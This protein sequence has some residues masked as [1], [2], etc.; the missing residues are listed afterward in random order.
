VTFFASLTSR[1]PL[2]TVGALALLAMRST[3]S[4]NDEMESDHEIGI[5]GGLLF[6]LVRPQVVLQG[7]IPMGPAQL[8]LRVGFSYLSLRDSFTQA[9]E[10][11]VYSDRLVT[12]SASLSEISLAIPEATVWL[13]Q[14]VFLTAGATIRN[15]LV[16]AAYT[17][18]TDE[19][20]TFRSLGIAVGATGSAGFR[21][22][23]S[24]S[25][26][27]DVASFFDFPLKSTGWASVDYTRDNSVAVPTLNENELDLM[28]QEL[29]PYFQGLA[30]QWAGG[31]IIRLLYL[32]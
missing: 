28:L 18:I 27:F 17:T 5:G 10:V 15:S 26:A 32:L 8:G 23:V 30:K 11:S 9:A 21:F 13:G 25:L 4:A 22:Y 12:N 3:A 19:P 7:A 2:L 1:V 16:S 29:E 31:A 24:P 6:P 14:S 20:L